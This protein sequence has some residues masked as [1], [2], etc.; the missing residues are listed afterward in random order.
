LTR[1][2]DH[3]HYPYCQ[4]KT[5]LE[6][7]RARSEHITRHCD[8][9]AAAGLILQLKERGLD[10]K[11][12][13]QNLFSRS[14]TL[15]SLQGNLTSYYGSIYNLESLCL[16]WIPLLDDFRVVASFPEERMCRLPGKW[17]KGGTNRGLCNFCRGTKPDKCRLCGITR[18]GSEARRTRATRGQKGRL[19][20]M[21]AYT[22]AEPS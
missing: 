14:G 6:N 12:S 10:I 2:T 9:K 1:V 20:L 19:P 4:Y 8:L 16:P 18:I 21:F 15:K 7:W 3:C 22:Q 5:S 17:I 13:F 11:A